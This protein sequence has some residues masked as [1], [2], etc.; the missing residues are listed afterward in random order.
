MPSIGEPML[1][2]SYFNV[3]LAGVGIVLAGGFTTVS[4]LGMDA[5]YDVYSEGGS[6]YPRYFYKGARP[7][8]LV[9]EQGVVTTV[10]S[11]SMLMTMVNQGMSVPLGGLITLQDSFGTPMRS[12]TIVGAHL[13]RFE[14]PQFNANQVSMAVNRVEFLY[15][16]CV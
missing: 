7:R 2:G 15:N 8:Q 14:G 16:G 4:G 11:M 1:S 3:A 9:L 13:L 10:D 5:D 6:S 12:W